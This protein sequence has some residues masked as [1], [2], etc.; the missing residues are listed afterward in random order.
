MHADCPVW[1][2]VSLFGCLL[3]LY[4]LQSVFSLFASIT[5]R[6]IWLKFLRVLV[7]LSFQQKCSSGLS[8]EV[9]QLLVVNKP[10]ICLALLQRYPQWLY[11]FLSQA[12]WCLRV[13][14]LLLVLSLDI[15]IIKST[16]S[17]SP[18]CDTSSSVLH[19]NLRP[20]TD[21]NICLPWST[22]LSFLLPCDSCQKEWAVHL[23][24]TRK[25]VLTLSLVAFSV[26][27]VLNASFTT[28]TDLNY[29]S[30]T[31]CKS[32]SCDKSCN[33]FKN[34]K[35]RILNIQFPYVHH[36]ALL[37]SLFC[38]EC[39]I[40]QNKVRLSCFFDSM[41]SLSSLYFFWST[42]KIN[43]P[44]FSMKKFS[45]LWMHFVRFI[46]NLLSVEENNSNDF[47]LVCNLKHSLG[48]FTSFLTSLLRIP[49]LCLSHTAC[50]S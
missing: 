1:L 14:S 7:L 10:N 26:C 36:D 12:D 32:P 15:F 3:H 20:S 30:I 27:C 24:M 6:R 43:Y 49:D 33:T 25:L 17:N 23:E 2:F 42:N 31:F 38:V 41:F 34:L 19:C 29:L 39:Y 37:L 13:S 47:V 45:M 22:K 8:S 35:F 46:F 48:Y 16:S 9:L 11:I 18:L 44:P 28:S 4:N 5:L 50:S 40:H 21:V